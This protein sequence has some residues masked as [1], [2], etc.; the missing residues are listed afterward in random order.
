MQTIQ[1][2]QFSSV[3]DRRD[4]PVATVDSGETIVVETEDAQNGYYRV[5]G[6]LQP[7]R[8]ALRPADVYPVSGPIFVRGAEPGDTLA[9]R[10]DDIQVDEQGITVGRA[11]GGLLGDWMRESRGMLIPVVDGVAHFG[12]RVKIPV[13]PMIGKMGTAPPL[14]CIRSSTPGPHGGNMDVV[15]IRAGSTLYLPVYVPG[16]LLYAGDVHAV[17]GDGEVCGTGVEIRARLTL[18]LTVRKGRPA[19]MSWPRLE[20]ADDI[21]VIAADKPAEA[22]A[23]LACKDMVLW[24]EEEYGFGRAEAYLLFSLVGDL[25]ICQLVNPLYTVRA[26]MPKRYLVSGPGA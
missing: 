12:G 23:R 18:T 9:V 4:A 19:S 21:M 2:H 14:E 25:R 26:V 20:T 6:S 5:P 8:L 24:M 3:L 10:V 11:G 13:R 1:R 15:D 7:D 22:A 16:G 17:M